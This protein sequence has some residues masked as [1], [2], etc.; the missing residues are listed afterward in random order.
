[1]RRQQGFLVLLAVAFVGALGLFSQPALAQPG[2]PVVVYPPGYEA[3]P[4]FLDT[5][6]GQDDGPGR[7]RK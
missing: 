4:V 7:A 6:L 3:D 5:E 1:M 2:P